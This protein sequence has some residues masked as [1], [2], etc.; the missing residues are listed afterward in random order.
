MIKKFFGFLYHS[1]I[2]LFWAAFTN[3]GLFIEYEEEIKR[4][5]G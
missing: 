1:V 5:G 4:K 3:G 2:F